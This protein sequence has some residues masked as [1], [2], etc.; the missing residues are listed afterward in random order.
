[1]ADLR[2][3]RALAETKYGDADEFLAHSDLEANHASFGKALEAFEWSV[4]RGAEFVDQ[5]DSKAKTALK[6]KIAEFRK[7]VRASRSQASNLFVDLRDL[8]KGGS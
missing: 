7:D 3:M 5:P 8:G 2:R 4:D 6:R 1:M